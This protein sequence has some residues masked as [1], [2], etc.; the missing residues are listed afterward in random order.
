MFLKN[1]QTI[2][3]FLYGDISDYEDANGITAADKNSVRKV[4]VKYL[5]NSFA[6]DDDFNFEDLLAQFRS[7][8]KKLS[9]LQSELNLYK[10]DIASILTD[11][12]VTGTYNY[13]VCDSSVMSLTEGAVKLT[14]LNLDQLYMLK[15]IS[16]AYNHASAK[17]IANLDTEYANALAELR[18]LVAVSSSCR[19]FFNQDSTAWGGVSYMTFLESRPGVAYK[20][21]IDNLNIAE[22]FN[23]NI[24]N[25]V[26][27][28]EVRKQYLTPS[29]NAF[30]KRFLDDT[31]LDQLY[32]LLIK[33][34][35][36]YA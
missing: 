32:M 3:R 19:Y 11:M 22:D 5:A 36:M 33:M 7:L 29:Q 23:G 30:F 17:Q 14:K 26:F 20:I 35:Q 9:V 34:I 25:L 16:L 27:D 1:Y 15:R 24:D 4:M 28:P 12:G 18:S 13:D 10:P 8:N 2:L 21:K 6:Y 31:V